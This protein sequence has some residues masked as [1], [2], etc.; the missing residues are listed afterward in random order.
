MPIDQSIMENAGAR[1]QVGR[2]YMSTV[3]VLS[4]A[5]AMFAAHT[6]QQTEREFVRELEHAAHLLRQTTVAEL[7]HHE[8]MLRVL[9][10]RL[11][12]VGALQEPE[13][14]R[15][16]VEQMLEINTSMAGFGLARAD[17]QLLLVSSIPAG[18]PLPSLMAREESR[19]GV[20]AALASDRMVVGRTYYFPLLSRWIIPVRLALRDAEGRPQLMMTAGIDIDADT[21]LWN[22]NERK[23]GVRVALLRDDGHYQLQ[24]P[25]PRKQREAI[26]GEPV[27]AATDAEHR[28]ESLV[29]LDGFQL[30]ALA[31]FDHEALTQG[32]LQRMFVPGFLFVIALV[33]GTILYRYLRLNQQIYEQSLVHQ[34]SH[35]VL[36][37]L[38]NRLLL[39]DRLH[40]DIARARRLN[41]KVAVMHLDL[42]QFKRINDSFDHKTGDLLL[43]LVAS[44]LTES[45]RDGDTIGRLGGDEFLLI[46]PDLAGIDSA[47]S[48]ALRLQARFERGFEIQGK[49]LF[50][51]ASI[52]VALFPSDG[53][54]AD[55]LLRNADSA[56][57]RAKDDGRNNVCFFHPRHNHA[58]TRRVVL[59]SEMR[60]ALERGEMQVFY[61]PKADAATLGWEGA[62]ALLRWNN[63]ELGQVSPLEFIPVAEETGLI[64]EIGSFVLKT[65]IRDLQR[66]REL[67]PDFAMAVNVS[68]RQFRNEEF[69]PRLLR[70]LKA[71]GLPPGLIELEVTE[72][73]MAEAVPQLE[74]LRDAGLRL[75][76]DDF[77]TGFSCLSYLKRLPVTTLKIDREF[78]RDLESDSADRALVTAVIAVARELEL[79]TVAEGVES[80]GQLGFLQS[81][82]CSQ[83]QGFL[84]GRPIP[85]EDFLGQ[86]HGKH[87]RLA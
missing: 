1:S 87:Q 12:E 45:Q 49:A 51:S 23:Q 7:A 16:L 13:R 11:Q 80:E 28:L 53:D 47:R 15:H 86:L 38:P 72:S 43:Q 57:H 25:A 37:G 10:R 39:K 33:L 18:R 55:T 9:G 63:P 32:F 19:Q 67:R 5:F 3:V 44:R 70:E 52:G 42:D 50:S 2:V 46:F 83:I 65:A 76:I 77:G 82:G 27:Q 4:L 85:F 81:Q 73:I 36:T 20:E 61:Q 48:L 60:S 22:A 31:R 40:Q 68:V 8:S 58:A 41:K 21:A 26:Y 17:G 62:E 24:L 78:V 69:I 71:S 79:D 74:V 29:P 35:D 30:N 54:N 59:E 56:L 84:L 75:A 34:A 14:G 6:W 66:I 64:E